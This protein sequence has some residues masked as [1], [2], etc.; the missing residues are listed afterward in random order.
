MGFNSGFKGLMWLTSNA[1][2]RA[3]TEPPSA[4]HVFPH[5]LIR[6]FWFPLPSSNH[7]SLTILYHV[8]YS[9]SFSAE[10]GTCNERD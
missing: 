1:G 5:V 3:C 10:T 8:I 7:I 6:N 2:P 9:A 4:P